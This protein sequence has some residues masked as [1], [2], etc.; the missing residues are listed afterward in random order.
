MNK[1]YI[2]TIST[3]VLFL[4]ILYLD[5]G[6]FRSLLSKTRN[7]TRENGI[8]KTFFKI[9]KYFFP[10]KANQ[11]GRMILSPANELHIA[12]KFE[13]GYGDYLIC[14]NFLEYFREK[15]SGDNIYYDLYGSGSL[16][17]VYNY[18][19]KNISVY[20]QNNFSFDFSD[21]KYDLVF[22]IAKRNQLLYSDDEKI[23]FLKPPLFDYI[24]LCRKY[25][26]ENRRIF[27]ANPELD[28]LTTA[29]SEMKGLK[30][31][32]EADIYGYFGVE[33][34][35]KFK[36]LIKEDE[37][38]YLKSIGLEPGNFILVHRGWFAEEKGGTHVKVWSLESC[39]DLIPQLKKNFPKY[40]IVL[41]G[42]HAFQ[43]PSP[44]G[45]DL[46]LLEQTTLNQA[47]VLL[48]HAA[49]LVDNE[50]GMV[51]L[52]HALRGG[53]SVVLFGPTSKSVFGYSENENISSSVCSQWCEWMTPEW[54]YV[55]TKTGERN[56][57]CMDAI[58]TNDVLEAVSRILSKG[59][60]K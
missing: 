38:S 18:D 3:S 22:K 1:L 59:D 13:G 42:E 56:H 46:N 48:K 20:P 8:P 6:K 34:N 9:V 28:S 15:F 49:V 7:S 25:M 54:R 29:A 58:T 32:Q 39:G 44:D 33:E 41:F 2:I 23:Q 27:D 17:D 16:K 10:K 19:I 5:K 52:R 36:I 53:S 40:K 24:L 50:G 26:E 21:G 4:L 11:Y 60:N 55:C 45:A 51:H 12:F 14:A 47:K 43:A 37:K 35:F 30:R 31:M 57:P